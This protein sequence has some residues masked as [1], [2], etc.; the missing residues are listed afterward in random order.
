MAK[1]KAESLNR[2]WGMWASS[3]VQ[4]HLTSRMKNERPQANFIKLLVKSYCKSSHTHHHICWNHPADNRWDTEE[5]YW[6]PA[7]MEMSPLQKDRPPVRRQL[8]RAKQQS[9]RH[10]F[11]SSSHHQKTKNCN[12]MKVRDINKGTAALRSHLSNYQGLE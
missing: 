10:D 8:I 12:E 2:P 3:Y 9:T 7:T 11:F 6:S 1:S 5:P 4:N